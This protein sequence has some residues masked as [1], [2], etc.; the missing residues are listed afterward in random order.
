MRLTTERVEWKRTATEIEIPV[1]LYAEI[2]LTIRHRFNI[3]GNKS[4]GCLSPPVYL[5]AGDHAP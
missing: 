3:L 5:G 2:G 1:Q 4:N